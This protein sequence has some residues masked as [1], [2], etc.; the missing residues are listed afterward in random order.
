MKVIVRNMHV[1][2][3]GPWKIW[4]RNRRK[5]SKWKRKWTE[6][7]MKTKRK[8]KGDDEEGYREEEND[9]KL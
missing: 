9:K 5:T 3:T 8:K 7:N 4:K 2:R 1:R 6:I